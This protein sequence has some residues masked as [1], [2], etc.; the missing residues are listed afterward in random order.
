M[1]LEMI[2]GSFDLIADDFHQFE[3]ITFELAPAREKVPFDLGG[4]PITEVVATDPS[5]VETR[6]Q[7]AG[8]LIDE[9]GKYDDAAGGEGS[10]AQIDG[11]SNIY[12]FAIESPNDF[13]ADGNVVVPT[14]IQIQICLDDDSLDNP[15]IIDELI[16]MEIDTIFTKNFEY[17]LIPPGVDLRVLIDDDVA[18][19]GGGA[20]Y[21]VWVFRSDPTIDTIPFINDDLGDLAATACTSIT[22]N[23]T[24]DGGAD[25]DSVDDSRVEMGHFFMPV[26]DEGFT[27]NGGVGVPSTILF[28][29]A[30]LGLPIMPG[31]P[32]FIDVF[33]PGGE[34]PFFID[35]TC[36][37]VTGAV[38]VDAT[39]V[40]ADTFLAG[41]GGGNGDLTINVVDQFGVPV[42]DTIAFIDAGFAPI[43]YDVCEDGDAFAVNDGDTGP[44][45]FD[46]V[47]DLVLTGTGTLVDPVAD[48]SFT[49][50]GMPTDP[51]SADD[52]GIYFVE[53]CAPNFFCNFTPV[54]ITADETTTLDMTV[55]IPG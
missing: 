23:V 14:T 24:D 33:G 29:A 52:T 39:L 48:G 38:T 49:I 26:F 32:Y 28:N 27:E 20:V 4:I 21:N 25:G 16:Q 53:V 54:T 5:A 13:D 36:D 34:F 50:T 7:T 3:V 46:E 11:P 44:E 1:L 9:D 17:G 51:N 40:D 8:T 19:N 37:D 18:P 55:F 47:F 22:V 42:S 15:V 2:N 35:V 6:C 10:F 41:L 12:G 31:G 43:I 45:C 30:S